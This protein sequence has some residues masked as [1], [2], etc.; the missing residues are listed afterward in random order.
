MPAF[1]KVTI[2]ALYE[3]SGPAKSLMC[4]SSPGQ[5]L[6]LGLLPNQLTRGLNH[7]LSVVGKASTMDPRMDGSRDT[8]VSWACWELIFTESQSVPL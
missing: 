8:L 3:L 2:A 1:D 5:M 6:T 7:P 4:S